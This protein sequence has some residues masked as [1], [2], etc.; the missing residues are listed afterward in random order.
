[1]TTPILRKRRDADRPAGTVPRV[2]DETLVVRNHGTSAVAL[3]VTF[4]DTDGT[5]AFDR[6]YALAPGE[7]VSTPTRLPRGVYR[8]VARLADA[9]GEQRDTAACLVGSAPGEAALVETG[10]GI[11][12]VTDGVV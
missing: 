7:T 8:V 4:L 12:S 10:N 2:T 11:V 9:P 3:G 1:M 5:V 6:T